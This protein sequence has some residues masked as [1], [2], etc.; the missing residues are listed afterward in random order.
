MMWQCLQATRSGADSEH[1]DIRTRASRKHPTVNAQHLPMAG[2]PCKA[3]GAAGTGCSGARR[4]ALLWPAVRRKGQP[5]GP[6]LGPLTMHTQA[7]RGERSWQNR[8]GMRSKGPPSAGTGPACMAGRYGIL[9]RAPCCIPRLVPPRAKFNASSHRLTGAEPCPV[10]SQPAA[11]ASSRPS[12][13]RKRSCD[14]V[15]PSTRP[16]R[17]AYCVATPWPGMW[18]R[19]RDRS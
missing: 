19:R 2:Q 1:A 5:A 15:P 12:R 6:G 4:Y 13:A 18:Q 11:R 3:G 9:L 14:P 16:A 7:D 10:A 17:W 8:G